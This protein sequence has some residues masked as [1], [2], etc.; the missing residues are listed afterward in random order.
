MKCV[1]A[2]EPAAFAF[3]NGPWTAVSFEPRG[4]SHIAERVI[5][6]SRSCRARALDFRQLRPGLGLAAQFRFWRPFSWPGRA[7]L[8]E[9]G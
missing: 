3:A 7:G 2:F 4:S 5:S 6:E 8:G 9:P 1:P